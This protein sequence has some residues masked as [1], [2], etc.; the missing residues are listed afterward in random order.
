MRVIHGRDNMCTRFHLSTV[1]QQGVWI[2]NCCLQGVYRSYA[3][4]TGLIPVSTIH[5]HTAVWI[6]GFSGD[7]YPPLSTTAR[8]HNRAATAAG[9]PKKDV[10]NFSTAYP[11][12]SP[13]LSTAYA[14]SPHKR[15]K[16]CGLAPAR[17]A[18]NALTTSIRRFALW[19]S[20]QLQHYIA[21]NRIMPTRPLRVPAVAR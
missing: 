21:R 6:V 14:S 15:G 1:C 11:Q 18:K 4:S 20:Q 12:V 19:I 5:I 7:S 3:L 17:S 13:P 9:L 16:L 8:V 2:V 10:R